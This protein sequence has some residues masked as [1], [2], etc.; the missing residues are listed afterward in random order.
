MSIE[1]IAIILLVVFGL[2]TTYII[3]KKKKF[4]R[5]RYAF[6]SIGLLF[7][8]GLLI[9]THL[10]GDN[11]LIIIVKTL[12]NKYFSLGLE[13]PTTDWTGK[14][15]SVIVF[16]IFGILILAFFKSW[17]GA[18]SNYDYEQSE[19][20][21]PIQYLDAAFKGGTNINITIQ[22]KDYNL[23]HN[24]N[25]K[26][27]IE[28]FDENKDWHSEAKEI[29]KLKSTQYK[30][31]DDDWHNEQLLFTAKYAEQDI[32][33]YCPLEEPSSE[34]ILNKIKFLKTYYPDKT[35][36][37]L[38]IMIKNS[39]K[40]KRLETIEQ[41]NIEFRYQ[42]ELLDSL[43]NFSEYFDFIKEEYL[44][45][46]ITDGD[47][48]K[49]KDIY[50]TPQARILNTNDDIANNTIL[51][52]EDY[53]LDW[54][55]DTSSKH[56]SLLGE[57][58]QGKSVLSLKLAYEMIIR[59][60][61]RIPIIIELR[62][63]SPKNDSLLNIIASWSSKFDISAKAIEKLL[64]AGKLLIILEGFDE[65]DLIGDSYTRSQHFKRL[66]EFMR[67]AKSKVIITG[68]PNLFLDTKEMENFLHLNKNT[69]QLFYSEP[70]HLN[71]LNEDQ[72]KDALRN[73]NKKTRDEIL[74]L[75]KN[76][77][78]N[79]SFID[80][81]ARPS[82]L[83]QTSIIWDNLD[84]NNINASSVVNE[85]I[86]HSYRRQETKLRTIG[87]TGVSPILTI[88]EREYFM[89]GIAIGMIKLSEYSNQINKNNLEDIIRELYYNIPDEI[90]NNE[91]PLRK[92]LKENTLDIETVFNDVR[93]SGILV[94][95][96]SRNDSFKFAHKSFLEFLF[97][98]FFVH[99]I[100]QK[101]NSY[102]TKIINS[103]TNTLNIVDIYHFRFTHEVTGFISTLFIN[104]IHHKD[105]DERL[106]TNF[107]NIFLKNK[108]SNYLLF[109][110]TKNSK[111]FVAFISIIFAITFYVTTVSLDM[112]NLSNNSIN[113]LTEILQPFVGDTNIILKNNIQSNI[114]NSLIVSFAVAYVMSFFLLIKKR[115]LRNPI[116][117]WYKTCQYSVEDKFIYKIISEKYIKRLF[118]KTDLNS[119][120]FDVLLFRISNIILKSKSNK[121]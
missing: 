110:L 80:L 68:R 65:M 26:E 107:L 43:V 23:T 78:D 75:I 84:I 49:P 119:N 76:K 28:Y 6:F 10:F 17:D 89:I 2:T 35:F 115:R 102:Y 18:T 109:I 83:Y 16:A 4:T 85:F 105:T 60:D 51:N 5:E 32:S 97:A 53:L 56:I 31:K 21:K 50:V 94:K 116:Q 77:N 59:K 120:L 41:L 61:Y 100:L 40:P 113:F 34:D 71:L 90:S 98:L 63:K 111:R 11:S 55:K 92:R 12:L 24:T 9:V 20:H 81:I 30:I 62:G 74:H 104:E 33:I 38:I 101:D 7:S 58:G 25:K 87:K 70:I 48:L 39:I 37:K 47:N 19:K 67:F 86:K 22:D 13:I 118:T 88:N 95:D 99:T 96:L 36:I 117:I 69:N 42:N 46:E 29:L 121:T 114:S 14:I 57:Y 1:I 54:S 3:F 91:I 103:I 45:K 112:I 8:F 106:C 108:F 93:T 52:V 66:L 73:I 15:L 64:H 82:T 27:D 44:H 79:S 72:I